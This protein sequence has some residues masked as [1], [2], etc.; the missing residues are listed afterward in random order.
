MASKSNQDKL[1]INI[2]EHSG[3]KSGNLAISKDV[4]AVKKNPSLVAQAVRVYLSNQRKAN[5][6]VKTRG[7]VVGSTRKI[8]KQKGT[9]KARHGSL[10]APIFVGGGVAHGPTGKENWKLKFSKTMKKT[11]LFSVLT[12]QFNSK[13]IC[14]VS[15]IS[16]IDPKTKKA[17]LLLNKLKESEKNLLGSKKVLVVVEKHE[18]QVKRAFRNL[19][20]KGVLVKRFE[21]LNCYLV[22]NSD[23]LIFDKK[24]LEIEK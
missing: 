21:D 23:Y 20:G 3:E 7:E 18:D 19:K 14:A 11:A 17:E 10:K 13:R 4:F 6:R 8:W 1:V 12:E 5:P 9:G 24:V 15:D 22:L 16:K 2:Y